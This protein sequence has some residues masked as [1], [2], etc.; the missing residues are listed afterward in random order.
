M[1]V[2]VRLTE[3]GELV[4][5]DVMFGETSASF[6]GSSAREAHSD[7]ARLTSNSAVTNLGRSARS[8][9]WKKEN[10]TE[11]F[12]NSPALPLA[13][14]SA[15]DTNVASGTV[16]FKHWTYQDL[17]PRGRS[18]LRTTIGSSLRVCRRLGSDERCPNSG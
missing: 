7:A 10:L 9:A 14:R 12:P 13:L 17:I 3:T 16:K 18:G 11:T 1:V 15:D 4:A 5:K 2:L 8:L 6:T